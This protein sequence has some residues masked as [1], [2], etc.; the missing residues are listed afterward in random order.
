MSSRPVEAVQE[1]SKFSLRSVFASAP[2]E[3]PSSP[4]HPVPSAAAVEGPMFP[5]HLPATAAPT[6]QPVAPA[7]AA[8]LKFTLPT[9]AA[10]AAPVAARPD[11]NRMLKAGY[12]AGGGGNSPEVMRLNTIVEDLERKIKK[13]AEKLVS[14]ETSIARGNQAL[15]SERAQAQARILALK[16]EVAAAQQREQLVRTEMAS[17]PRASEFDEQKFKIQAEGALEVQAKL[18][19]ETAKLAALETELADLKAA[20]A[21]LREEHGKLE[22]AH[23][24]A[25]DALELA[26]KSAS[27]TAIEEI[28][29]HKDEAQTAVAALEEAQRNTEEAVKV[30]VSKAM[31]DK[32][33][34]ATAHAEAL[35]NLR[36]ELDGA[37]KDLEKTQTDSKVDAEE[38]TQVIEALQSKLNAVREQSRTEA[39]VSPPAPTP[40]PV[41]P[42]DVQADHDKYVSM[43]AK[44][45][46][47]ETALTADSPAT[48][49]AKVAKLKHDAL[50]AFARLKLGRD[51]QPFVCGQTSTCRGDRSVRRHLGMHV[52]PLEYGVSACALEDC[53]ID[54]HA[55][56]CCEY[57][58]FKRATTDVSEVSQQV[59]T[60]KLVEALSSD[61]K[62]QL[63]NRTAMW[64]TG[65]ALA[66]KIVK[67]EEE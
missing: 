61:L 40:T 43:K 36:A 42:A 28:Q 60:Q 10:R 38:A 64:A 48:E 8:G 44:A 65:K 67:E 33:A 7:T 23:A 35:Q 63:A 14:A 49:I 34:M 4:T 21:L 2:A 6:L 3:K 55:T 27:Q 41:M 47:A 54:L 32:D 57:T 24:I 31:S 58:E 26:Q 5:L 29:R 50:R 45:E 1:A 39:A 12:I 9:M 59:R 20:H 18:D 66:V 37:L 53:D 11:A 51:P 30:V 25:T 15:Q 17:I 19:S 22:T 46:A 16:A 62:I 56:G 52:K 13:A